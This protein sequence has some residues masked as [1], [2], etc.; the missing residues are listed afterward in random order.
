META[1]LSFA[2][3]A[4]SL[5]GGLAIFLYGMEQLTDALKSVAGSSLKKLLSGVTR[6]RFRSVT[7]GAVITAVIQSSSVTTVLTV[8]F[9]SAGLMTL[10][11]SI[12]VI[13]GA[14][15]GTTITAQIVA[16]KVTQFA[17]AIV[18]IGFLLQFVFSNG[19]IRQYG[20][21]L[22]GLGLVFFG[23]N[24]MG[25]ATYPLRSYEPFIDL[26]QGMSHPLIGITL[27]AAFTAV[28]QSSSATTGVIIVLASQ[29]LVDL[30]TGIALVF[31]ANIGTTVTA[32]LAS[33]GKSREALRTALVNVIFHFA[34]VVLWYGFIEQL[35][36][37]VIW[38]SPTYQHL[39]GVDRLAAEVPRQIANAHTVFN[40]S[41]TLIFIWLTKPLA[42]L[43]TWLA[44]DRPTV[45][46]LVIQP[47]YLDDNLFGTPSLA[48]DRVRMEF[49]HLGDRVL[50]MQK[51]APPAVLS[52]TYAQLEQ[53]AKMDD[54]VDTLDRAIVDY[55]ATLSR[56]SLTI[57][58]T[59]LAQRYL[60]IA[61]NYENMADMIETNMVHAGH[62]RLRHKV[63]ISDATQQILKTFYDQVYAAVKMTTQAVVDSDIKLAQRVIEMK[64][65]MAV[66]AENADN[67]LALRL[68]AEDPHRVSTYRVE[69]AL[70]ENLRRVYYFAKRI[71][72]EVTEIDVVAE[73]TEDE[74][75]PTLS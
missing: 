26:M 28:I 13:M 54:A 14:S 52:G 62:E 34:G 32:M 5:L 47:K 73:D 49:E 22:L 43:V 15:I 58:E 74:L 60:Q 29:G 71:A 69:S 46:P 30:H 2:A 8:G 20:L 7:A 31:G 27:G 64:P 36:Q 70:I 3:M 44:P 10:Q 53:V 59:Q 55:L 25:E 1:N 21:I 67:H 42:R 48:L 4:M 24:L 16:F 11:Q 6:N 45:R 40:V 57:K 37:L 18:A 38:L 35:A 50:A 23:M 17:L 66:L 68:T 65:D 39:T 33:I 75:S 9:V 19:R 41:N 51:K 12:G 63:Q 56:E 72:K 61:A